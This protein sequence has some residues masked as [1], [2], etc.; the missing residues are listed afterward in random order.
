V[1]I[2]LALISL[3]SWCRRSQ[4]VKGCCSSPWR[5]KVDLFNPQEESKTGIPVD[6]QNTHSS[7]GAVKKAM[8]LLIV[9]QGRGRE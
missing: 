6:I 8:L 7:V 4:L 3:L 9:N 1:Y 2:I 5:Y